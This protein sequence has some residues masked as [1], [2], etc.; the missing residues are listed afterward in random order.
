MSKAKR[1]KPEARA[2]DL[3]L[4]PA[5]AERIELW[6]LQRLKPYEQNARLHSDDQVDR[7][8]ASIA[9]FGFLNPILVDGRDGIAAGHCRLQAAQRLGLS[10]VPV[11]VLDHLSED[12]RRAYVL[13]DNRLAELATWDDERVAEEL[14][15]LEAADFEGLDAL[16]WS[17]D[18]LAAALEVEAP[19]GTEHVEFEATK[20]KPPEEERWEIPERP[21][22]RAGD[23]W[24]LGRHRILC[25]D[26]LADGAVAELLGDDEHVACVLTDPPYAIYGSATGVS[27]EIADSKL[28]RPFFEATLR[29]AAGVVRQW[30]HVYV[31]CDWRSWAEWVNVAPRSGLKL[32]NM[33]VWDKGSG[34][35]SMFANCHELVGFFARTP[36]GRALTS[37]DKGGHRQVLAPNVLHFPRVGAQGFEGEHEGGERAHNAA[38][39]VLLLS[40]LLE[41]STDAG[42]LV[43]DPFAGSGSTLVA[44]ET[45]GRRCVAVEMEPGMVDVVIGRWEKASKQRAKLGRKLFETVRKERAES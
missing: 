33:L 9:R 12:D 42:E 45:A 24:T 2:A 20:A 23:V 11:V 21:V 14:R 25:G 29:L 34:L 4:T 26:S 5:L 22:T 38:K 30:G 36:K 39:P 6:D 8:A 13:A 32:C 28:V 16:G 43:V 41:L 17:D 1:C 40:K 18:E 27:S 3:E 31:F 7:V 35:G 19:A 15:A 37:R 44:A 10:Q